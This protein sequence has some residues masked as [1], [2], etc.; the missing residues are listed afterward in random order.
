MKIILNNHQSAMSFRQAMQTLTQDA[1]GLSL[2]VSYLQVSGL[3]LLEQNIRQMEP[4]NVRVVCTDQMGITH[5][6][7]VRRALE[8][9][10]QVRNYNGGSTYHPK[11][12][13]SYDRGQRPRSFLVS[14][15]N[16]SHSA[17]THGVEAGVFG[18]DRNSLKV[19]DEWFRGLFSRQSNTISEQDLLVMEEQWR[20]TAAARVRTHFQRIPRVITPRRERIV[21]ITVADLDAIEDVFAT[22]QLPIG[23]VNFDHSRNNIRNL[24]HLRNVLAHWDQIRTAPGQTA[25][26]QRSELRLL[27]L[28]ENHELTDLG[29]RAAAVRTEDELARIWCDWIGQAADSFLEQLNERLPAFKRAAQQ[30]WRLQPEVRDFFLAN[31]QNRSEKQTLQTVELLCNAS[32]I[33]QELSLE[34]FRSLTPLIAQG[35]RLPEYIR[36]A[37]AEYHDN[38]G[39]RGWDLPDR[40]TM[41]LAWR[42][43]DDMRG[44]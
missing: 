35:E 38:K 23:L 18:N 4:T 29:R 43:A 36:E 31:V 27:G 16:L 13:L 5:P 21:P 24:G 7:A 44:V 33:V 12:Y 1:A 14:S 8:R 26:K 42:E 34:N 3:N 20:R 2:A 10:I 15:A 6:V 37:V 9:H 30:F 28:I 25:G 22:I 17:F 39:T 40:R 19:L 32:D 11:V 41:L